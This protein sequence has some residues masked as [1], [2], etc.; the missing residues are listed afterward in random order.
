MKILH[1]ALTDSGGA[2]IGMMNQHRAL[3]SIGIKSRILVAKKRSNDSAVVEMCPN[4]YIWS[5]NRYVRFIQRVACRLGICFNP[6]DRYHYLIYKV[7]RRHKV[8]FDNPCSQYDVASHPLVEWADVINLHYISGFVDVPSFFSKICKPV[9]WTMRDENAGLG[10]FH[11]VET[12]Q[13]Y[14]CFYAP[15]EDCF[16]DI[17]R[18]A[19][20][21]CSSLFI[22]SLSRGMQQFCKKTDFLA[23]LSNIIIPNAIDSACYH[24]YGRSEARRML[25]LASDDILVGFVCCALGEKRKGLMLALDAIQILNEDEKRQF[26]GKRIR[27][28][29]V[30]KDD[31]CIDSLDIIKLGTVVDKDRLSMAYSAADI[32]LNASSQESFGKTIIEALYCGIPVVSTPVGIA[33]E[34][35]GRHNGCLCSERTPC[36]I[37]SAI[38]SVLTTTYNKIAIRNAA[39]RRFAPEKVAAQYVTLYKSILGE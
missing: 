2:G 38:M 16:F 17:K 26:V 14:Y 22:V 37:A 20:N 29:C 3:L 24:P 13:E 31:I 10:G 5:H 21:S 30:G 4:Q 25:N 28:L 35:I 11:Y 8:E 9:V 34:I 33:P 32:F 19:I 27:L 18:R 39:I 15:L 36:S 1:I 12:R 7:R 23:A 6:Y